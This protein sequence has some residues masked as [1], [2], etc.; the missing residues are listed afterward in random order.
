VKRD[1][2]KRLPVLFVHGRRKKRQHQ[3][4][5]QQHGNIVADGRMGQQVGRDTNRPGSRK[6]DELPFGQVQRNLGFNFGQVFR[7]GYK[8]EYY[9]TIARELSRNNNINYFCI[10][11]RLKLC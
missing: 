9:S 5:H 7:N 4:D 1:F 8:M 2:F 6:T 11:K 3:A 10:P